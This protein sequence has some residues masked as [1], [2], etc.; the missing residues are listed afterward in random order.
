MGY[1]MLHN[2]RKLPTDPAF[3][4]DAGYGQNFWS[5]IEV[6]YPVGDVKTRQ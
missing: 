5:E 6:L 1:R 3:F 2:T 4:E